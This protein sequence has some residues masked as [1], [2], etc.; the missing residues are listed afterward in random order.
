MRSGAGDPQEEVAPMTLGPCHAHAAGF[1]L[2]AGL[3]TGAGQRDRLERLCRY[4]LRPPIAQDRLQ[5]TAEGE[6]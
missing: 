3:V 4:A 6:I 2:H 1:D 5:V